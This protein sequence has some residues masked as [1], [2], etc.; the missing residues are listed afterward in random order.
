MIDYFAHV[1]ALQ[2]FLQATTNQPP[3]DEQQFFV[4]SRNDAENEPGGAIL[5]A[6]VDHLLQ[7]GQPEPAAE[8]DTLREAAA[9]FQRGLTL[10]GKLSDA[11]EKME[12]ALLDPAAHGALDGAN[13]ARKSLPQL[14]ADI[15]GLRE[16][17]KVYQAHYSGRWLAPVG[18]QL[19][20]PTSQ[21][22]WRDV[23]LARGTT[24]FLVKAKERAHTAKQRAFALGALAGAAGNLL[25]SAY[26]NAVVGGPRRSHRLRHRLAAYSVGAW[27]RDNEPLLAGGLDSL[28]TSLAFGQTGTPT[29]PAELKDF[30][31]ATLQDTYRTGTAPLPDL[32][33]GYRNLL[34]HLDLLDGFPLPASPAALSD[35]IVKRAM[36]A[37]AYSGDYTFGE[38]VAP[39]PSGLSGNFP[40]IGA[41]ESADAVCVT[42]LSWAL[43]PYAY[44]ALKDL[45]SS[46]DNDTGENVGWSS[47]AL[48]DASKSPPT[49]R[50]MQTLYGSQTSAWTALSTA[51]TALVLRGLLYPRP[52]DLLS[53]STFQ[54]FLAVPVNLGPYPLLPMPDSDDGTTWPTS[55][56]ELHSTQTSPY[57]ASM[58]PLVFLT[59]HRTY[60]VFQLSS[61]LWEALIEH[62]N[63]PSGQEFWPT[64]DNYNLDGDRGFQ[65]LCWTTAP[66]TSIT[67]Q[68]LSITVLDFEEI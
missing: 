30:L 26:L 35:E 20:A 41:H 68:P 66:G 60:S 37:N 28:R 15:E 56:P 33:L 61:A 17:I 67:T 3:T 44:E 2:V 39:P 27:L 55:F 29:L 18:Q 16:D 21:W 25:G 65:S 32:D 6:L 24:L 31:V 64:G 7:Y 48:T 36:K 52:E 43:P 38:A 23:F 13:A 53:N 46:S 1:S 9:L 8:L 40:G 63:G 49:L 22:L 54:Q 42:I 19:D 51:R 5:G 50:D 47:Q 62:P 14:S 45:F 12:R 34:A 59:T 11:R 57:D 10:F 4:D 58:G